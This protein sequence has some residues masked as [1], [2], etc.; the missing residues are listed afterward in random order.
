M[1]KT[2]TAEVSFATLIHAPREKVYDAFTKA[3]ELNH[4]FTKSSKIDARPGG[5]ILICWENWGVDHYTGEDGGP[6]LEAMRPERFVFQWHPHRK[7]YVTTVEMDFEERADGTVMRVR[8]T[9][10]EDSPEGL[11]SIL[12]NAGGWGEALTLLKFYVEHGVTY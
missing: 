10:V 8:E 7:D 5:S 11:K 3:E 6:V 9:G 1:I 4:W 12:G 2:I